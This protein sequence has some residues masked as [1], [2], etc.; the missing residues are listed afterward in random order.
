[1]ARG[2]IWTLGKDMT[3]EHCFLSLV[4]LHLHSRCNISLPCLS[5]PSLPPLMPLP[6]H[7][8]LWKPRRPILTSSL[9]TQWKAAGDWDLRSELSQS[10]ELAVPESQD[11]EKKKGIWSLGFSSWGMY[12]DSLTSLEEGLLPLWIGLRLLPTSYVLDLSPLE[13]ILEHLFYSLFLLLFCP[14]CFFFLFRSFFLRE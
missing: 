14:S 7:K 5:F 13:L 3:F 4:T 2:G 1:M 8:D 12:S 10:Q 11:V 9:G 6:S